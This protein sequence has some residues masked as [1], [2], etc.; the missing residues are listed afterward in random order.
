MKKVDL[1]RLI[2][3]LFLLAGLS[4]SLVYAVPLGPTS[5]QTLA[6]NA[7]STFNRSNYAPRSVEAEAGNITQIIISGVTQT[8]TWQGYWGEVTG[9]I[10][11]DDAFNY[12]MYDWYVAEPQG[13]IF[14]ASEEV[15]DW[16]TI[17]CFNYSNNGSEREY[18]YYYAGNPI[19]TYTTLTSN[20]SEVE[21]GILEWSLGIQIG[22]EDGL[23]ETFNETGNIRTAKDSANTFTFTPHDSFWVG[24]T[25]ITAGSCPATKTY[26]SN[27]INQTSPNQYQ[28]Y[29]VAETFCEGDPGAGLKYQW[30][31]STDGTDFQE[32]LLTINNS[33]T[34]IYTTLIENRRLDNTTEIQGY[35]NVTHDFQMIVG[36][37]GHPGPKQFTT[38][39]Y[40]FYV[41]LE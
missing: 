2:T 15:I 40:Y 18:T 28:W 36:D 6:T 30:D 5:P 38:T 27:C 35:N 31:G 17:S 32:V 9:T 8:Q 23:D 21:Q 1:I 39:T 29:K 7:T 25:N 26:Q 41:E 37:D 19:T 16:I 34:L 33:K 4:F 14:A 22:D 20:L 10:T 12:T 3:I 11:L 24:P 13:E